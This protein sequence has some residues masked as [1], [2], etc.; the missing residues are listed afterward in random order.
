[1]TLAN[2]AHE[3]ADGKPPKRGR[4]PSRDDLN[5]RLFFRLFQASNIYET[6]AR[7]AFSI[8]AVQGA[9][10]GALSRS[11]DGMPL[12]ELCAYLS[13]SRQNAHVVFGRLERAGLIERQEDASDRRKRTVRLT[14]AG[15]DTWA[16][17]RR[18]NVDFFRRG[19]KGL[20]SE[21]V[22]VCA[23]MLARIRRALKGMRDD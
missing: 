18:R 5:N 17:L 21:E 9:T 14:Q 22:E 19:T 23:D 4:A 12:A 7:W 20:T 1:L 6:Q 11:P 10:L 8:S 15:R 2:E 13:V 3:A 16:D